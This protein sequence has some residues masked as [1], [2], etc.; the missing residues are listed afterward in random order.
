MNTMTCAAA[1]V[2][3]A[4]HLRAGRNGQDAASCWAGPGACALVVCDGCSSSPRSE[5]GANLG[6]SLVCRALA[7][8]LVEGARPSDPALWAAVR[9]DVTRALDDL[10]SALGDRTRAVHDYLLFTVVSVAITPDASAAWAVGDG[11]YLLGDNSRTLGPFEDNRPAYLGYDLL[12]E[13]PAE[14]HFEVSGAVGVA[15]VGTDGVSEL[16]TPLADLVSDRFVR[17]PDTLRR[18]LA[19]LAR[20]AETIDWDARR[21]VRTPALL[22]D[23][24]AAAVVRVTR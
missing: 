16:P 22:Q 14:A 1:A 21:V 4:R 11:C 13:R 10:V 15:A 18:H 7:R 20:S 8:R 23:D 17:H 2:T 24:G 6:A 5:V 3:G 12:G 9:A 19:V